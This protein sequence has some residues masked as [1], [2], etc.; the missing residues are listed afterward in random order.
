MERS[1]VAKSSP[2][3]D[4]LELWVKVALL[5]I[6][7]VIGSGAL[8]LALSTPSELSLLHKLLRPLQA[9]VDSDRALYSPLAYFFLLSL[10]FILERRIPAREQALFTVG[11]A[12]DTLWYVGTIVFRV[13]FLGYY[14]L[15]LEDIYQQHFSFLTLD[16]ISSW[17][18]SS[19]FVVAL[20]AADFLRWL[21]HLIRHKV[22]LFWK[23][24]A[25]HHSQSEMN[26][27][28]DARVHP[29]DRMIS[30]TLRFIPFLML[31]NDLPVILGW[32]I[33]ET[34]YPKFYHANV[35]LN[36]GLLRYILV[37]PQSHRVHHARGASYRD[38][39]FGFTLSIWDRVF[40]THYQDDF[41]YPATGVTDPDYPS[42]KVA[43]PRFLAVTF[44]RQLL[45]P[46]QQLFRAG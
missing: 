10:V 18:A 9:H 20:L 44:A 31:G 12:Q 1:S 30:A 46:F 15:L 35:R 36:F 8:L 4:G 37:T 14:A 27:F 43:G 39:N 32:A 7:L 11:F 24:H 22:P 34:I 38:K 13:A 17:G 41:D 33:F 21:S 19:R 2:F 23:F 28:T 26:L 16:S 29:V 45:Y 3:I 6:W 42:E 40:G 5:S 25:V